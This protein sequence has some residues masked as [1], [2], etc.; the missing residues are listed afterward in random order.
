M[1]N[2]KKN[3]NTIAKVDCPTL[4]LKHILFRQPGKCQKCAIYLL[5]ISSHNV[6]RISNLYLGNPT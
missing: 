5:Q 1:R 6:S 3:V 2:V 4:D